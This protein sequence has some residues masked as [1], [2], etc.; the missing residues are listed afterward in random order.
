MMNYATKVAKPNH[1]EP[2][3]KLGRDQPGEVFISPVLILETDES[4]GDLRIFLRDQNRED[5]R[6][7]WEGIEAMQLQIRSP[8]PRPQAM[9]LLDNL[10]VRYE[11]RAKP[12]PTPKEGQPC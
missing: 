1:Y 3:K 9:V 5:G 4:G 11:T 6:I 7:A 2:D 8:G 12:T 10:P